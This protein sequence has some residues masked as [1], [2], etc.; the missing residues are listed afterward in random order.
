[1]SP[2]RN[3]DLWLQDLLPQAGACAHG[4][5]ASLLRAM[6]ASFTTV[7]AHLARA[8]DLETPAKITRNRLSRWLSRP[9]WD[10]ETIYDGLSRHAK[11]LLARRTKVLLLVDFTDLGRRW[12]V[13]SVSVPFQGRAVP[14]YRSVV[15]HTA[16]EIAQP[17]QVRA[18]LRWLAAHLPGERSRYVVVMDRGFPSHLLIRLLKE[19]AFRFVI[20][21][22]GEW[23]MTHPEY[24]GRFKEAREQTGVGEGRPRCFLGAVL[25]CRGKGQAYWSV[26]NVAFYQGEGRAEPWYLLTSEEKGTTAVSIYRERMRIEC[27]FRDLKGPVGLD[28]LAHWHD[29][30]RV[31]RLLALVAIYE[32]R[33]VAL[34]LRHR[35]WEQRSFFQVKGKLSWITTT[36]LWIQRQLQPS[37]NVALARL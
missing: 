34:W 12:R 27:E 14:V 6:L 17:E 2:S 23:K 15:S 4:A 1:M 32:W 24:T 31:A 28:E 5:A 37:I 8:I 19:E 35:L 21:A 33:L 9:N 29:R 25:G 13:L 3:L 30:E 18:A 20:R 10:P 22:Q 16:P 36:R 26:A 7:L 11:R